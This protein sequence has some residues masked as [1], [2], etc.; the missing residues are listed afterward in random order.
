MSHYIKLDN[1][2]KA[3]RENMLHMGITPPD[4]IKPDGKIHRFHIQ[5]DKQYTKNGWYILHMDRIPIGFYSDWKE[6][7]T[8]KWFAI[9]DREIAYKD[10]LNINN[11]LR[12]L[13]A[14]R[15]KEHK[16]AARIAQQIY[17]SSPRANPAHPYLLKKRIEPFYACQKGNLLVL[18]I[19]DISGNVW[20][21]QYISPTGKKWF[22]TGGAISKHFIPIYRWPSNTATNLICE[23]YA[24]GA[25]LA[26]ANPNASVIATCSAGNLKPV[27]LEIRK[28]FPNAEIIICSDDDRTKSS[29]IGLIKANEAA[30]SAR[31]KMIKPDWPS[32]SP[33]LLT[34]FNDLYCWRINTQ[35]AI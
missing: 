15:S 28:N 14:E 9:K 19:M 18:P 10:H 35:V 21:L 31:A 26:Q 5:G 8:H 27:A 4:S 25:T 33:K 2:I 22:F 23:G 3:F 17:C 29:N 30:I 13:H 24:T 16:N 34:D 32:N 6:G 1:A 12:Q 7:V 20:S 11:R